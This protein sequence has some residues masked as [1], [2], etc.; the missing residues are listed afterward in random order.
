LYLLILRYR[1]SGKE[2]VVLRHESKEYLQ[3]L[4]PDYYEHYSTQ[5]VEEIYVRPALHLFISEEDSSEDE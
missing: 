4:I 5:D 2:I 1:K 3:K